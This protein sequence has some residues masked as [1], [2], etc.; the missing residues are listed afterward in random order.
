M[1]GLLIGIFLIVLVSTEKKCSSK[2][3]TTC[4]KGRL[5]IKGICS[6]YTIKVL[7]GFVDTSKVA[8]RWTDENTGKTYTNVFALEDACT[9]PADIAEGE[10][11]YFTLG[12]K[13][14]K[15]C[16]VCMAYYPTPPKRLLINVSKTPC[17]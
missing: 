2:K 4:F 1:K 17:N 16:N 6:N 14:E 3:T 5:E 13:R 10:E 15:D 9:F 11:F 8:A 7:E 12:E